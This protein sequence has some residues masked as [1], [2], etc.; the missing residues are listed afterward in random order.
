MAV[1]WFRHWVC[2]PLLIA[3]CSEEDA[4]RGGGGFFGGP[5]PLVVAQPATVR[6]IADVVEAI[7]TTRANESVTITAKVTD[8]IRQVRFEDGDFVNR[9]DIL[10]EQ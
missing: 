7:G 4:T 9:G 5:P 8:S 2:L 1:R 6:S 3:G 10:V